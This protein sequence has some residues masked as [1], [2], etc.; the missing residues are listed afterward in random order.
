MVNESSIYIYPAAWNQSVGCPILKLTIEYRS[1]NEHTWKMLSSQALSSDVIKLS[2]LTLKTVY[3]VRMTAHTKGSPSTMAEY[4]ARVG[5]EDEASSY[6][7]VQRGLWNTTTLVSLASSCIIL[8]V[9]CVAVVCFILYERKLNHKLAS[10]QSHYRRPSSVS[11]AHTEESIDGRRGHGDGRSA[12]SKSLIPR[13]KQ[14]VLLETQSS[15]GMMGGSSAGHIKKVQPLVQQV[16]R[17]QSTEISDGKMNPFGNMSSPIR[18]KLPKVSIP[19]QQLEEIEK[20][21]YNEYDEITPYATFRLTDAD[22]PEGPDLLPEDEFKTFTMRVG[23]PAY[24]FKVRK[25][26]SSTSQD[27]I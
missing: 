6:F 9:G 27:I 11:T 4:E 7:E 3:S 2:N 16:L 8:L 1:S 26:F 14:P 10:R 23:E 25:D 22:V 20:D 18:G 17:V 19:K 5:L 24:C 21:V 12:S 13:E 15:G